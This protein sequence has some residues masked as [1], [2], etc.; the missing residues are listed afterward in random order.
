MYFGEPE[1]GGADPG[2]PDAQPSLSGRPPGGGGGFQS[3]WG[4]GFR[5]G[6]KRR[7]TALHFEASCASWISIDRPLAIGGSRLGKGGSG[8]KSPGIFSLGFRPQILRLEMHYLLFRPLILLAPADFVGTAFLPLRH[9]FG[10]LDNLSVEFRS[11]G[12]CSEEVRRNTFDAR[13]ER[14]LRL[15]SECH[16]SRRSLP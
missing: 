5:L 13:S 4:V 16:R 15:G 10:V 14:G 9:R 2:L 6:R 3:S 12:Y 7:A 1:A 11:D 8:K